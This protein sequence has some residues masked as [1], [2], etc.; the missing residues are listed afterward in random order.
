MVGAEQDPSLTARNG[1]GQLVMVQFISIGVAAGAAAALLFASVTS[2]TWLSI[3]LFYLAPLPIM[4]AGIGW[5]HWTALIAA[6]IA[7]LALG[8][9]FN[10]M[11]FVA[12][13][14]GV[15]G[16]AWWL[17][18][19]AMLSRPAGAVT[20]A[21]ETPLTSNAKDT[22]LEWYPPG[23]LVIWAALL[24]AMMVILAIPSFGFDADSFRTSLRQSLAAMLQIDSGSEA[25]PPLVGYATNPQQLLNFFVEA[26]PPASA[27][28][29]TLT[30]LINLWLA[31]RVIK[32]S[33]RLARPW[34][35]LSAMTFPKG[36]S[37]VFA[38]AVALSF[39]GDLAGIIAGVVCACLLT[40]YSLLGLAVT[41][42]ITRGI[43][44]RSFL[45]GGL[46][47]SIFLLGWP[48]LLLCLAGLTESTIGLRA[49]VKAKHSPPHST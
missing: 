26:L 16:P 14:G 19:L 32:F 43:S 35:S 12:F 17:S 4:I 8:I 15:G 47:A 22:L 33:G 37:I 39:I 29:A 9:V 45:L 42:D 38:V 23:Q 40:A 31:A 2:G 34:P 27:S 49:R 11:F 6:A 21:L 28:I 10:S 41:H 18:Y 46:Y 48:I 36:I 3:P 13:L 25:S 30:S 1:A 5:S 7:A 20:R 24:A 44:S